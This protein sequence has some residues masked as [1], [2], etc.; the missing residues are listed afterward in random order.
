MPIIRE[1]K[2]GDRNGIGKLAGQDQRVRAHIG[3]W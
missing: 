3:D 1:I 2:G